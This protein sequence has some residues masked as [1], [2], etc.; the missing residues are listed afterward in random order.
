MTTEPHQTGK[1][2][3]AFKKAA[4]AVADV[5]PRADNIPDASRFALDI[6]SAQPVKGYSLGAVLASSDRTAVFKSHDPVMDRPVV[7]KMMRPYPG[8]DGVVEEFFSLAG[9]IARLRCSGVARGLDV[10]RADG[11]FYL[12]YE[13]LTGEDLDKKLAKRPNNRM[14]ERESARLVRDIALV[15]QDLF[16]LGQPHGYLKP[17]NI[18]IADG[19][20]RLA[21][22]GFA[23]SLAWPDDDA[24]FLHAARY[25]PPERLRGEINIDVRGDLYSLGAIWFRCLTGRDLFDGDAPEEMVRKH[26]EV[27]PPTAKSVDPKF[28]E[29][30][31][32]LI[33]WLLEKDRDNRPRTPKQFLRHLA[34]HPLLAGDVMDDDMD[35][36]EALQELPVDAGPEAEPPAEPTATAESGETADP[37][38]L[39]EAVPTDDAVLTMYRE[40]A[41]ASRTAPAGEASGE[42]SAVAAGPVESVSPVASAEPVESVSSLEPAEPVQAAGSRETAEP[43][44]SPSSVASAEPV[45]P[46]APEPCSSAVEPHSVDTFDAAVALY[47]EYAQASQPDQEPAG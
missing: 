46:S 18:M 38:E 12:V 1:N 4:A 28:T 7:V 45:G 3:F 27:R 36:G 26:L 47:R 6:Q 25:L 39:A 13:F 35:D 14:T 9:S 8:R 32:K 42:S 2:P 24:A 16:S 29:E 19:R 5:D 10:G 40:Y 43:V 34:S 11:V 21:D 44:E 33:R 20:P 30:T 15:L 23:W 31:S 22:I 37:L 41:E 17:S